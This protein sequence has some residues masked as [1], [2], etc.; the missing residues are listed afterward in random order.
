MD[1]SD[2]R[3]AS[4]SPHRGD[5]QDNPVQ[6]PSTPPPQTRGAPEANPR[7]IRGASSVPMSRSSLEKEE[8]GSETLSGDVHRRDSQFA[9][10]V[11]QPLPPLPHARLAGD[12]GPPRR[13]RTADTNASSARR[14]NTGIEWIVPV[15][16]KVIRTCKRSSKDFP[17]CSS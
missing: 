8:A 2:H 9:L 4:T 16:E 17:E 7:A 14:S 10:G 13:I 5:R 11:H 6:S 12:N 15:E 1:P 3:P